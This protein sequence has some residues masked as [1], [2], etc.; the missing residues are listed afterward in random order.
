LDQ[1]LIKRKYFQNMTFAARFKQLDIQPKLFTVPELHAHHG[2]S[3]KS[4]NSAKHCVWD[5]V[6]PCCWKN[7]LT[8]SGSNQELN[9]HVL[10]WTVRD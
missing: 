1:A 2:K 3:L 4:L 7:N 9:A 8:P 6:Y 10:F 5:S